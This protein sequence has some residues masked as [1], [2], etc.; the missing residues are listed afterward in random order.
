MLQV[1][2]L[3]KLKSGKYG[4]QSAGVQNSTMSCW[5]VL[6][7][8]ADTKSAKRHVSCHDMSSGPRGPHAVSKSLGRHHHWPDR[9]LKPAIGGL[10]LQDLPI[11]LLELLFSALFAIA[12]GPS[13]HLGAF[14]SRKQCCC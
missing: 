3:S 13:W 10:N 5:V 6:V 7:V 2:K 1:E 14:S 9:Q 11:S 4:S 12:A 8:W